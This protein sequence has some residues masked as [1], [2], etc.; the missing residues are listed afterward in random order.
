M[1]RRPRGASSPPG[2][3]SYF[4]FGPRGVGKSSWVKRA[5]PKAAYVDLLEDET[6]RRLLAR[7]GTLSDLLPSSPAAV[8]IDEV[9]KVPALLDEVHRLIKKRR[10]QFILTGSSARKLKKQGVNLLAGRALTFSLFPLTARELGADFDLKRAL[11]FGLLPLAVTSEHPKLFLESYVKTYLKE[12]VEQEGL[13]RQ[14]GSFARFLE[15][16]SFSQAALLSVAQIASEAQIHRKVVEDY[17]SI[18]R[19]LLLSYELPVFS[20]R[21]KR[22]MMTKRKFYFFDAGLYRTI[23]PKGPLDSDAELGGPAFETLCLQ[24]LMAL[25]HYLHAGYDFFHW[26]TRRHEEVDLVLYGENGLLAFDFKSG[27]RLREADFDGLRLFAEDYPQARLHLIH[28]GS[29]RRIMGGVKVI[30]AQEFFAEAEALLT[31]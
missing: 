14:L 6:Y 22:E 28:G 17:F 29:E 4:L 19:D 30:P 9:Q 16:A 25:N 20:R 5:Y 7:P 10:I 24:E 31:R 18:L 13:T 11:R 23:R 8:I 1:R 3:Q 12:E 15:T 21:A 27:S 2:R 26:R